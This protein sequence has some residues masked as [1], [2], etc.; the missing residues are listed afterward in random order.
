M[1][2]WKSY[3]NFAQITANMNIL[4][5][6]KKTDQNDCKRISLKEDTSDV[7]VHESG[8]HFLDGTIKT[9]LSYKF[10]GNTLPAEIIRWW[11]PI[12]ESHDALI[13]FLNRENARKRLLDRLSNLRI[14]MSNGIQLGLHPLEPQTEENV[15]NVIYSYTGNGL[16]EWS[17]FP[18]TNGTLI[19]QL[20]SRRVGAISIGNEYFSYA[21]K[22]SSGE[23]IKGKQ[24]VS[25]EA[26]VS[27]M[28]NLESLC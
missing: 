5:P 20:K 14:D 1:L 11:Q 25:P 15:S 24:S 19:F 23:R 18:N 7:Y 27:V 28:K 13:E 4:I 21:G 9:F 8:S 3:C 12:E 22:T 17:L 2:Y 16:D 6:Y 26:I 10:D